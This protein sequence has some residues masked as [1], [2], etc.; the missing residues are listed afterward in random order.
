MRIQQ[1]LGALTAQSCN[2]LTLAHIKTALAALLK[3]SEDLIQLNCNDVFRRKA[4]KGPQVTK[5]REFHASVTVNIL[6]LGIGNTNRVMDY[7][8]QTDL[9]LN[10][11]NGE[12]RGSANDFE[13]ADE[14]RIDETGMFRCKLFKLLGYM[15]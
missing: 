5:T 4:F 15:N 14:P 8:R 9:F 7:T 1:T 2:A 6:T 11:L 12:L 10:Q 3:I 13:S